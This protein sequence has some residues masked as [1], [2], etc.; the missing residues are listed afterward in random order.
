MMQSLDN[1][2]SDLF[3]ADIFVESMGWLLV[4]RGIAGDGWLGGADFGEISDFGGNWGDA[5]W[6]ALISEKSATLG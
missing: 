6:A 4:L 2:Q 5:D 3:V 1:P